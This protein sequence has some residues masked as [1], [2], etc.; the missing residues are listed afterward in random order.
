MLMYLSTFTA[1]EAIATLLFI[2]SCVI[3]IT[4]AEKLD[5]KAIK[6]QAIATLV[7]AI[8]ATI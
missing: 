3:A 5:L 4:N 1:L 2:F 8:I 6:I 7:T